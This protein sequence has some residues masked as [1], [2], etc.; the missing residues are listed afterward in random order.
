M[1]DF[2]LKL[3]KVIYFFI[4]VFIIALIAVI[5]FL[6]MLKYE[7]EGEGNMPFELT[8]IVTVS[9]A[10]GIDIEGNDAWNFN[11][12][13]NNDMYIHIAKNIKYKETEIIKNITIDNIEIENAPAKGNIVI[14]RPSS[15]RDANYEY[16]DEYIVNDS[17]KYEGKEETNIKE[18][19]VANQGGVIAIR[20]CNKDLRNIFLK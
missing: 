1:E 18:L 6:L 4:A 5:I 11:L 7:V 12:V 13:Q 20:F 17:L 14:Y 15:S 3:R 19:A 16:E 2:N 8:Q 10:Q 9:T